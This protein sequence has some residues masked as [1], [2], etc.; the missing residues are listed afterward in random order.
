MPNTCDIAYTKLSANLEIFLDRELVL[1]VEIVHVD[2]RTRKEVTVG[3]GCPSSTSSGRPESPSTTTW[4]PRARPNATTASQL[5][6][7]IFLS[8]SIQKMR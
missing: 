1:L 5:T 3:R 4:V 8:R 2:P 6:L 7:N